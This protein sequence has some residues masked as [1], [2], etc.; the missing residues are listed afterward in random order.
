MGRGLAAASPPRPRRPRLPRH[1]IALHPPPGPPLGTERPEE[2][3]SGVSQTGSV[4]PE[5]GLL[6][7]CS[8]SESPGRPSL[9]PRH[10]QDSLRGSLPGCP[11]LSA[12]ALWA[13]SQGRVSPA[14]CPGERHLES[15]RG[16]VPQD[17]REP[18][19]VSQLSPTSRAAGHQRLC[20]RLA[21]N[22][23]LLPRRQPNT[24]VPGCALRTRLCSTSSI[25]P[26][27]R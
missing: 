11:Q 16:A 14:P 2:E 23:R 7:C 13:S 20:L 6:C 26:P 9:P 1:T 17:R 15:V 25:R 22:T 19:C 8:L 27:P 5:K 18:R 3:C 4:F 21:P 12:V 24:P 10:T